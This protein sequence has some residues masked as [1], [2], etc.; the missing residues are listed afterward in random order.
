MKQL[1]SLFVLPNFKGSKTI[2]ELVMY[3]GLSPLPGLEIGIPITI[4]EN[5]FTNLHY[6]H[7]I[8][9]PYFLLLSCLIGY[10]TYGT[11]RY[12]DALDYKN[13]NDTSAFSENKINLYNNI[14]EN[15]KFIKYSLI[16]CNLILVAFFKQNNETTPFILLLFIS[17]FY[18]QIKEE[19]GLVKAPFIGAM[20]SIASIILPCVLYEHNYNILSDPSCYLPAFFALIAASNTA[21]ISDYDEDKRNNINT[22]PVQFGKENT[23]YL[24]LLLLFISSLLF[25]LNHNYLNRPIINSLFELNNLGVS[26]AN[27]KISNA[28][29]HEDIIGNFNISGNYTINL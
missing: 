11:D 22:F 28:S 2:T 20:W 19:F 18:K 23:I 10:V 29:F 25:G 9:L 21:D 8:D 6:G 12:Y 1:T 26:L 14:L 27:F 24:N 7:D 3:S 17:R 16:F 15:E 13:S 5:I 4:F